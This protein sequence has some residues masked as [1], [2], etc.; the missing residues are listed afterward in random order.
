MG[1]SSEEN[2]SEAKLDKRATVCG[3]QRA[4]AQ[5]LNGKERV[6]V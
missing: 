3:A 2:T 4:I 5:E 6:R 1:S